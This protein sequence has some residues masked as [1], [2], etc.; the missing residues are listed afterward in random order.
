MFETSQGKDSEI[1]SQKPKKK[2]KRP[3]GIAQGVEQRQGPQF[4]T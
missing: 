3:G 1:L 2:T 4:K